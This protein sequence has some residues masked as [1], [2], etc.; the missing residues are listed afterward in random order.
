MPRPLRLL[1]LEE[2]RISLRHS[3]Y[4]ARRFHHRRRQ[5]AVLQALTSTCRRPLISLHRST[6]RRHTDF[7]T[8]IKVFFTELTRARLTVARQMLLCFFVSHFCRDDL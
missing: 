4:L 2:V 6:R 7:S 1:L 8:C 3:W 5:G